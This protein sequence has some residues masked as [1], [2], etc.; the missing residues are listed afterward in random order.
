MAFNGD[1]GELLYKSADLSAVAR[2]QAPIVVAGTVY[3]VSNTSLYAFRVG[4]TGPGPAPSPGFALLPI[5]LAEL[6]ADLPNP[7]DQSEPPGL[8]ISPSP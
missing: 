2:Y 4:T 7:D 8:A 1:T 3:V 5:D 6:P